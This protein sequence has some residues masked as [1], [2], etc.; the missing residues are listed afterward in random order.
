MKKFILIL[1][2]SSLYT[3]LLSQ[4]VY[5]HNSNSNIYEFL[6]EMAN[7]KIIEL[8][9][10]VKPYSRVFI[11]EKLVEVKRRGSEGATL[12]GSDFAR[13]RKGE[14][15]LLNKRQLEELDFYLKAYVLEGKA[16]LSFPAKTNLLKKSKGFATALNPTG[17]FYKDS[18]FTAALQI[19]YG[20]SFATNKNGNLTKTYGGGS[21]FGYIGKN[22]GFYSSVRD[23]NLSR[24]MISPEYFIKQKGAP[25][26]NY[27]DEGIDFSEARG[28]ITYSW[29]WGN[30]GLIKDHL[31]WG[32]GYNGTNIQSGRAPS[33]AMIKLNLKPVRWFEF[34]YYHGWLV[35]EVVDS[36]SSYWTNGT[37]RSVFYPK[38]IAANMFTFYP[39]R[40]FNV[41]FGN[42]IVYSDLGGP[43]T[44]YL[45]PFL[46][47][48]SVDHTLNGV[49][50]GGEAGQNAQMF[51][52]LSSR[53]IKH[54]HIYFTIH[55]DDLSIRHFRAKDEYNLFSY[56]TGFRLSNYPFQ[57]ISLTTEFTR[58]NPLVYQHKIQTQTYESNN[59]NMGH[60]LRDNSQELYLALNY[61]PLRGLFLNLSYTLAQHYD[62]YSYA[63]CATT[64]GCNLHKLPIFDNLIWQN[65]TILFQTKY[66]VFSN[67]YLFL[68][69]QHS[70]VTGEQDKIE[71]YTPEYY[72]GGTNTISVGMNIGF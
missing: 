52:S 25:F 29:K 38:Y 60:Y 70:N 67:T 17:L 14:K 22:I 61:K 36:A 48:K 41:S 1:L 30:I 13:G 26:K 21:V 9:D 44:A 40:N 2:L 16:P 63:E 71:K 55:I 65:Q 72:W 50:S 5:E 43:H 28:G 7:M 3:S 59:Y 49:Y 12:R 69:Y 11:Y 58:T 62:D 34:N 54:L 15:G 53:N 23:N 51:L 66:E 46:F 47:Y 56:K 27:G 8:N 64:P 45:I 37:Y 6:D 18:V 57:N 32:T 33:F 35:S 68:N 20:A 39:F 42:S 24:I 31:E 10:V 19:I 4:V